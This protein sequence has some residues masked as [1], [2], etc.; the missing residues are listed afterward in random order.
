LMVNRLER[1]A[2]RLADR[3]RS[4]AVESITYIRGVTT[5]SAVPA[6][7]GRTIFRTDQGGGAMLREESRD[8]IVKPSDL[9]ALGEPQERDEIR[10]V[11]GDGTTRM[12]RVTTFDGTNPWK[13]TDGYHNKYRIHT[14]YIKDL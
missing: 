10:E 13:W 11:G 3:F 8:F 12:Y 1:G 2:D 7:I 14:K 9:G 5:L 4:V 6:V